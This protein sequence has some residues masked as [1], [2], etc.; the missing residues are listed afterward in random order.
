MKIHSETDRRTDRQIG[1]TKLTVVLSNFKSAPKLDNRKFAFIEFK[2]VL[3]T[4]K[5]IL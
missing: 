2:L 5:V 1:M 4:N 3:N